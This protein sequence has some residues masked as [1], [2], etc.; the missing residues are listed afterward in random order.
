MSCIAHAPRW[1]AAPPSALHS[2]RELP[3]HR[4]WQVA[5]HGAEAHPLHKPGPIKRLQRGGSRFD[6]AVGPVAF[7][8]KGDLKEPETAWFR[9]IGGRYVEID[10]ATLAPPIFDT[11]P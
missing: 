11:T 7:D 9:W 10:P 2:K 5:A 4:R 1:R 8:T 6:T 3:L